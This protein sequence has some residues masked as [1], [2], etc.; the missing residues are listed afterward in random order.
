M[1][2]RRLIA[3]TPDPRARGKL[4]GAAGAD[5]IA[6]NVRFYRRLF[7]A[8]GVR[9]AD[10]PELGAASVDAIDRWSS[11]LGEEVR[12]LADGSG[13]PTWELGMLNAR[14]EILATVGATGEGECS[15]SVV[16]PERGA[17]ITLQTWD[18]HDESNPDAQVVRHVTADGVEVRYFAEFGMLGKIGLN[19]AGVGVHFNILN[20]AADGD[21]IGVPVHAVA[22]EVLD[23]ARGL[24]EA[25]AIARSARV[26]ASTVLTLV[27]HDG[28][29]S[30][31]A[32]VELSAGGSAVIRP[33]DG[34]LTHTNHFL[35]PELARGEMARATSD[36]YPRLDLLGRNR[37]RLAAD[38]V[39]E[40]ALGIAVHSEDGAPLCCHADPDLP[41]HK[42][43]QTLLTAALDLKAGV[44]W[45][46]EG[47]PCTAAPA[48]WQVF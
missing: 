41:F 15:T 32:C 35:D 5:G 11:D 46:H 45:F 24:D 12:G 23:R 26:S 20:H 8:V 10:L 29:G 9:P 42:R 6:L 4:V 18:W 17:P 36:S 38:T 2:V 14:T 19:D 47:T 40:R 3:D 28:G 25:I 1:T 48:S 30:D 31:A 16:L 13:R 33:E 44:L 27:A 7:E 39:P 34:L 22:R 37:E 21:G 43:W